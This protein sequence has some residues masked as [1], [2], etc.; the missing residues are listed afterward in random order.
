[1][2]KFEQNL[3]SLARSSDVAPNAKY[4][5]FNRDHLCRITA[6]TPAALEAQTLIKQIDRDMHIDGAD[7]LPMWA[8]ASARVTSIDRAV[9][10][11]LASEDPAFDCEKDTYGR[12]LKLTENP[13]GK[14]YYD[15]DF[16]MA[17][18]INEEAGL[19]LDRYRVRPKV[20]LYFDVYERHA[21]GQYG[22][23]YFNHH[24]AKRTPDGKKFLWQ[25]FNELIDMMRN[26][27]KARGLDHLERWNA[28]QAEQRLRAMMR[29]VRWC[30]RKRRRI[31]VIR[32]DLYYRTEFAGKVSIEQA[33]EHHALFVNRLR[34]LKDVQTDLVGGI[35]K[36]EWTERKGHHVHWV[37]MLDGSLV[38]DAWKWSDLI[39]EQWRSAV[40][41]DGGYSHC[42]NR[43]QHKKVGTGMIH[44][45]NEPEKFEIFEKEVIGY[46]AKKDQALCLKITAGTRAWGRFTPG[47]KRTSNAGRPPKSTRTSKLT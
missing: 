5:S 16:L 38:Q 43:D 11:I 36:L 7:I 39:D 29:Y 34:A 24:P 45:D 44:I 18:V 47:G 9:T 46:L 20:Q 10:A 4:V 23:Q 12:I 14:L 37:L 31:F 32:M 8:W 2:D 13:L 1:M 28:S 35:W 42:G 25:S 3:N 21:V 17:G 27:A 26:E 40:P 41:L 33:K 22:S 6:L 30:F 15:R 19:T